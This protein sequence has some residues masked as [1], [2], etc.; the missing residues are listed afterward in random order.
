[1]SSLYRVLKNEFSC[2]IGKQTMKFQ[3]YTWHYYDQ[4]SGEDASCVIVIFGNTS[5]GEPCCI[6]IN[7]FEPW[8]YIELPDHIDWKKDGKILLL[9]S[10]MN[11]QFKYQ[12]KNVSVMK[13]EEKKRLYYVQE[14]NLYPYLKLSFKS[15][16]ARK[17][18]CYRVSKPWFASGLGEIGLKVH[19]IDA[20]PTLQLASLNNM[21]CGGWNICRNA[22][23]VPEDEKETNWKNEYTCSYKNI[24]GYVW[25]GDPPV[26]HPSVLS[27]DLECNSSVPSSM[28]KASRTKDV[29]FQCSCIITKGEWKKKICL[30]LKQTKKFKG[31][32]LRIFKT[33]SDLL[34]GFVDILQEFNIQVI[35]GWNIMGFDIPYMV[36]RANEICMLGDP[37]LK[38]GCF[39]D[40]N[41]EFK[42]MKWSSSAYKA[43]S[44]S[45]MDCFGRVTIDLMIE[46]KKLFNLERYRLN[47]VARHVL[48]DE[49]DDMDPEGIFDSWRVGTPESLGKCAQYC[50]QDGDL[51]SRLFDSMKTWASMCSMSDVCIVPILNLSINGQQL[52]VFSQVYHECLH[53]NRVVEKDKYIPKENDGYSGAIVI[54]P[55]PGLYKHVLPFDFASLYPTIMIAYNICYSTFVRDGTKGITDDMC[56]VLEFEEHSNCEHSDKKKESGKPV[57]CGKYRFRYLKSP[58]G[59]IPTKLKYLLEARKNVRKIQAD[60]KKKAEIPGFDTPEGKRLMSIYDILETQQLALKVSC[61][62]MYGAMGVRKGYLPF[63]PGAMSI[64]AKGRES[65]LRAADILVNECEAELVYGD[66]DSCMVKFPKHE[67]SPQEIWDHAFEIEKFLLPKFRA[68]MKLEFEPPVYEE[69]LA[70]SKKRYLIITM[71]RDGNLSNKPKKKGVMSVRRGYAIFCRELYDEVAFKILSNG[72]EEECMDIMLRGINELLTRKV[73]VQN[74]IVT[75]AMNLI[76]GYKKKVVPTDP[77]AKKEFLAKKGYTS[78]EQFHIGGLPAHVQLALKMRTRGGIVEE[79]S[80]I[81]WIIINKRG[82][83]A[84]KKCYKIEDPV[85]FL[86]RKNVLRID[87]INYVKQLVNPFDELCSTV[88][89]KEKV[90]TNMFKQILQKEKVCD[91]I[92]TKSVVRID[93]DI[94]EETDVNACDMVVKIVKKRLTGKIYNQV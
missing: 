67:G 29:I 8:I 11:N 6:K 5:D 71:D 40:R 80:R 21:K 48:K 66:T 86:K 45:Y 58:C 90:F 72:T 83:R 63:M 17:K 91:I 14:K 68:P 20:L 2:K 89:K 73:S 59:V 61:N 57:L 15:A 25:K 49:K 37:F 23:F 12:M 18:F 69:Y 24:K 34:M 38:W 92:N 19:E 46:A 47:D 51:V 36:D 82:M 10:A 94:H 70:L 55:V 74:L 78:E 31:C 22:N 42:T 50:V 84:S 81:P 33:E 1:M 87:Y 76:D 7:D 44:F 39:P 85:Y 4:G 16:D 60:Y 88:W 53:D 75:T 54:A 9:Q 41:T 30:C 13:F 65:V 26:V 62:S 32:E 3:A 79:G 56:H 77:L 64:T 35:T 43:Q 93:E 52:K 27:F 28:P